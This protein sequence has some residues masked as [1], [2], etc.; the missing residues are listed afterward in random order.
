MGGGGVFKSLLCMTKER[1]CIFIECVSLDEKCRGKN[2][3]KMFE[4]GGDEPSQP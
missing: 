1:A 4:G 2:R 3:H